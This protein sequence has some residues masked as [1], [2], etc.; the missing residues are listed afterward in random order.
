MRMF[1]VSTGGFIRDREEIIRSLVEQA[2][3]L[4]TYSE[5]C[6]APSMGLVEG[7]RVPMQSRALLLRALQHDRRVLPAIAIVL[8]ALWATRVWA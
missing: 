8:R 7:R 3:A 2:A 5:R 6:K 4:L 1:D